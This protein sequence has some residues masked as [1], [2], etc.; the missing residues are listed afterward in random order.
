MKRSKLILLVLLISSVLAGCG[1]LS[2][3][4][5]FDKTLDS[6]LEQNGILTVQAETPILYQYNSDGDCFASFGDHSAFIVNGG[7]LITYDATEDKAVFDNQID[8]VTLLRKIHHFN[9]TQKKQVDSKVDVKYKDYIKGTENILLFYNENVPELK[10]V[11]EKYLKDNFGDYDPKEVTME[12]YMAQS[13]EDIS[14]IAASLEFVSNQP[15]SMG[16]ILSNRTGAID[17]SYQ[18][19]QFFQVNWFFEGVT[20]G[21]PFE[22]KDLHDKQENDTDWF[23]VL[24]AKTKDIDNKMIDRLAKKQGYSEKWVKAQKLSLTEFLALGETEQQERITE[25]LRHLSPI[26]YRVDFDQ[27][28]LDE[29][30]AKMKRVYEENKNNAVAKRHFEN[31]SASAIFLEFIL[32]NEKE[33]NNYTDV[34]EPGT[35]SND[36]L[37]SMEEF[38]DVT[39]KKPLDLPEIVPEVTNPVPVG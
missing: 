25:F 7:K 30:H 16:S 1:S 19:P 13:K 2:G 32:A 39:D 5:T 38:V 31:K 3:G 6:I 17:E 24:M 21:V 26:A 27:V 33:K 20:D 37:E 12:V 9:K 8:V 36:S 29:I 35:E 14:K 34:V 11:M 4:D 23:D 18:S 28:D 15:N 10:S 22:T